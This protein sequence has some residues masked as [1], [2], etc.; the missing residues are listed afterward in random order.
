[1]AGFVAMLHTSVS[2]RF[3]SWT[4]YKLPRPVY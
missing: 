4:A 3:D 1:M 2:T